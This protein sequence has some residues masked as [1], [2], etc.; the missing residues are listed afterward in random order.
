MRNHSELRE[1]LAKATPGTWTN[2]TL[3]TGD[4]GDPNCTGI[5]IDGV[6]WETPGWLNFPD[7][8]PPTDEENERQARANAELIVAAVNA[9]PALLDDLQAAESARSEAEGKAYRNAAALLKMQIK[10][11][12]LEGHSVPERLDFCVNRIRALADTPAQEDK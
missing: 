11:A 10:Q 12:R 3:E 9:L 6:G 7:D 1:K 8:P 2:C 5:Y 4:C